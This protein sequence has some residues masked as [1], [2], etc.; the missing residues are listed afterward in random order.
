[1]ETKLIDTNS[2]PVLN[3]SPVPV[4]SAVQVYLDSIPVA[5]MYAMRKGMDDVGASGQTIPLFE[6][7]MDAKSLFLTPNTTVIYI[8]PAFDLSKGPVVYEVA[9]GMMGLADDA[10]F[11]YLTDVGVAGPDEGK[12]GKYLLL[13]PDYEGDVPTE[14][15][16][17]VHS[18]SN[19][20]WF[21]LRAFVGEDGPQATADAV[22]AVMRVY[23]YA[24][25]DNPPET[26]F[27]DLSGVSVNTLHPA[28]DSYFES[29][30]AAIQGEPASAFS[31]DL[32]GNLA[33]LGIRQGEPF[34][35]DERMQKIFKEAAAVGDA[36]ARSV[37]F[38]PRD[39]ESFVYED[40]Q[41]KPIFVGGSHEFLRDGVKLHEAQTL[42][43]FYATGTTPAMVS[44]AVGAGTQYFYAER[45]AEGNYLDGGKTYKITLP[46][47]VPVK[48][49]WSFMVYD[50]QTRSMLETDQRSAGVD[51][52]S[53]DLKANDDGS[54][55]IWFGPKAPEGKEELIRVLME[56]DGE[57]LFDV[58]TLSSPPPRSRVRRCRWRISTPSTSSP[59][60]RS[61]CPAPGWASSI[62]RS[63]SPW[64][65]IAKTWR[66][67]RSASCC[68]SG[69]RRSR[70]A[71]ALVWSFRNRTRFPK[72]Y[73]KTLPMV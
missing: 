46:P 3:S 32:L 64:P 67:S 12:G 24:D 13:P 16:H 61:A 34:A 66:A 25:R 30:H 44:T 37:V 4:D 11:K 71:R 49:F 43:H 57:E 35:P 69:A 42:F 14:G 10:S 51:S 15:Y 50:N 39:R 28:D 18:T 41:W 2:K 59:P 26:K 56:K 54:Y 6:T 45:D 70:C 62:A 53:P 9:P 23:P 36:T 48:Q 65:A 47:D 8:T 22:K 29:L 20:G 33:A 27:K 1:M 40:R 58:E 19:N 63:A 31:A 73:S 7:L 52:L 38:V 55:T 21:P 72:A 60:R 17:V 68:R 5:S